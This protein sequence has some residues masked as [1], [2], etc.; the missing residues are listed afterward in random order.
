MGWGTGNRIVPLGPNYVELLAIVEPSEA[1]SSLL[2][3]WLESAVAE[4][5]RLSGWA[6]AVDRVDP[7]AERL[8]LQIVPGSRVLPDGTTASWRLAGLE[9]IIEDPSLP[10]FVEW[11]VPP[12]LHPGLTKVPHRVHPEGVAWIQVSG[13][14]YRFRE[15]LGDADVPLRIVEGMPSLMEAGIAT[16]EGEIV[17]R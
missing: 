2:G 6:V 17:L 14:E 16:A 11:S 3:M 12:E 9:R 13:H 1:A 8:G 4:G 10:F 15:W 7:V 5:D